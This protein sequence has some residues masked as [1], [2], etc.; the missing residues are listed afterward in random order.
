MQRTL[1]EI[2]QHLGGELHG[3]PALV[4][5][6]AATL[7]DAKAGDLSLADDPRRGADVTR[8]A[9]SAVIAPCGF[10]PEG[11]PAI[12]VA[13]VH[14]AFAATVQLFRPPRSRRVVGVSPQAFVSETAAIAANV[15]VHPG[16]VV[17]DDVEIGPGCVIHSGACLMAGCRL[18][19]D[20]IV[21]PNAVLYE[22][23]VVGDR[24]R[25]HGGAVLGAYGFGYKT[26]DGR[27]RLGA[28]LGYVKVEND[29]DIGAGTTIDR[30][31]YGP[32]VIGEGT[33]LDNQVMIGH[34]CRIGPHNLF[35]AQVGVAG[36]TTTGSY[37]VMAGQAG[38]RDHVHI[39]DLAVIGPQAGVKDNLPGRARYM[40]T[41]ARPERENALLWSS[42]A[43]LPD[44]RK[45]VKA[46]MNEVEQLRTARNGGSEKAA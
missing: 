13:D 10:L 12:Q 1:G 41:P 11:R 17:G 18:G 25:I 36:S 30:G 46:M 20:V 29:V 8:S 35:C 3:D 14:E 43:K 31:S 4:I 37:V 28:Q 16:A 21:F 40:G 45:Q 27:H 26:V 19:C 44:L 6:G 15:E 5:T 7:A 42:W 9:A 32:T 2:A 22:D 34:N 24:V 38:V 33:K 39:G 23:T